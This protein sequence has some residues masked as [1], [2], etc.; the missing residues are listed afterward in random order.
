MRIYA[1]NNEAIDVHKWHAPT[2]EQARRI[3]GMALKGPGPDGR[4]D[5]FAYDAEHPPYG[6]EDYHCYICGDRMEDWHD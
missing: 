6:L 2:E 3:W 4:G 1:S 5:C